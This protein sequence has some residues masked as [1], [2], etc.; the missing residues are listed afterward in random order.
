MPKVIVTDYQYH[1][2]AAEEEV[3][4]SIGVTLEPHQCRTAEEVLAFSQGADGILVQYFPLTRDIIARLDGCRVISCY[5]IGTDKVDLEA[6]TEK[7]IVVVNVPGYCTD[8]VSDHALM[9]LLACA[10]KL[11]P[12][13]ASTK[14]GAWDFNMVRPVHRLRGRTLGIVGLGRIGQRLAQ[15]AQPLGLSLLAYDPFLPVEVF[16]RLGV[17]RV[18]LKELLQRSDYVSLHAPL[19]L[20]GDPILGKKELGLMKPGAILINTARGRVVDNIALAEALGN[21]HLAAAGLDVVDV[22]PIPPD[23]PLLMLENVILTPH[24]AWY[25][26][27]AQ[28]ELQTRAALGVAAVLCGEMPEA[29]AN[30]AVL[31]RF[32]APLQPPTGR[33]TF[34]GWQ[35]RLQR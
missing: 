24:A 25:S 16:T 29:V 32:S 5:A 26:E 22:E 28:V 3:F 7:G 33:F 21:G 30:P 15:K 34:Q 4:A 8:E 31:E 9:L 11:V 13:A 23:H 14:S 19:S 27:E 20:G 1:S 35:N 18:E 17:D 10:R 2:L 12:L 6:A